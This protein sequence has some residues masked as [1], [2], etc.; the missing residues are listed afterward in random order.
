LAR[1]DLAGQVAER[2]ADEARAEVEPEH[3]RGLRDGLEVDRAVTRAVRSLRCLADEI[4]LEKRLEG[5]RD[6]RLRDPRTPGDLGPRDRSS[7][8]DRVE[9]R[10]LVEVTEQRG[11]RSTV[12]GHLVKDINVIAAF[13]LALDAR[14]ET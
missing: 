10:A 9:H 14:V 5:E 7:G 2:A 11:G 3:D 8:A 1:A 12:W 13:L 6:R 4:G